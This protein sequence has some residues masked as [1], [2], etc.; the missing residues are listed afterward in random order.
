ME[1]V[2]KGRCAGRGRRSKKSGNFPEMKVEITSKACELQ[3]GDSSFLGRG[4]KRSSEPVVPSKRGS[5][6]T[7]REARKTT[8]ARTAGRSP[9]SEQ[10]IWRHTSGGGMLSLEGGESVK[11]EITVSRRSLSCYTL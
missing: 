1:D 9:L 11:L 7:G 3:G 5:A 4:R 10:H 6:T 8:L 2:G